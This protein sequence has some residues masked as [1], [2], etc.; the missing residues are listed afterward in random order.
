MGRELKTESRS[1]ESLGFGKF[2]I[3]VLHLMSNQPKE[4]DL[5]VNE[6]SR[7]RPASTVPAGRKISR[8]DVVVLDDSPAAA[9][10]R[11]RARASNDVIELINDEGSENASS[12]KTQRQVVIDL[13]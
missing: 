3:R 1:L 13:S 10:V 4:L 2:G 8:D 6:I 9:V 5:T 7:K 12:T 11:N